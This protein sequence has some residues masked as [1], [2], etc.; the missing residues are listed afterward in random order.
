QM[1]H[2]YQHFN[3]ASIAISLWSLG[4]LGYCDIKVAQRLAYRAEGV[5]LWTKEELYSLH[6]ASLM[7]GIEYSELLKARIAQML[8]REAA[9]KAPRPS[10]F[11]QEVAIELTQLGFSPEHQVF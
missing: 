8:A 7:L 9:R 1:L 5:R 2:D 11:E 6:H 4:A 10:A 3:A